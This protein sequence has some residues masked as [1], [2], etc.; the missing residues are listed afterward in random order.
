MK[1]KTKSK[2]EPLTKIQEKNYLKRKETAE[3]IG[4][5]KRRVEEL[6]EARRKLDA[7]LAPAFEMFGDVRKLSD[8]VIV[9]RTI[10]DI[11]D[12]I[13][14]PEMVGTVLRT[15]FSYPRFT[16]ITGD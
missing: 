1:T 8:G 7:K 10:V 3:E 11:P 6:E 13:C 12:K 4:R 15:G 14:E 9:R 2:I 16:E 5:L